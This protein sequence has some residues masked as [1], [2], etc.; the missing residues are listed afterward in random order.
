[1]KK[2]LAVF[3]CLFLVGCATCHSGRFSDKAY[4]AKDKNA[5]IALSMKGL[6]KPYEEIGFISIVG[7]T[8]FEGYDS[9]N[10]K[11]KVK[12]RQMGGDAIINIEYGTTDKFYVSQGQGGSSKRASSKGTV[13]VFTESI[14]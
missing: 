6:D 3:I 11:M 1:M 2:L 10:K 13:V 14:E 8:I 4:P 5:P 9:L 12:A 7:G